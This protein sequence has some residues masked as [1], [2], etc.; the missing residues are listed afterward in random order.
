MSSSVSWH[1]RQ[2]D[3]DHPILGSQL[4]RGNEDD[5][6]VRQYYVIEA[7]YILTDRP[8]RPGAP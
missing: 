3:Q 1:V 5:V 4:R 7:R 2:V 8:G 6:M